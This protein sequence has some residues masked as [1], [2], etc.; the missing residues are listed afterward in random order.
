MEGLRATPVQTFLSRSC[1]EQDLRLHCAKAQVP[2]SREELALQDRWGLWGS[3]QPLHEGGALGNRVVVPCAA[4][5][6]PLCALIQKL[7][8]E[9]L[10][11]N[12]PAAV[13]LFHQ[14]QAMNTP[15][16]PVPSASRQATTCPSGGASSV[17]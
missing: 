8:K 12:Q 14:T 11:S 10:L 1:R 17:T 15:A 6:P 4:R 5:T 9:Q 3:S 16:C 7:L 13:S 2:L